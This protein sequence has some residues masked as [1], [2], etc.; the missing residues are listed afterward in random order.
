MLSSGLVSPTCSGCFLRQPKTHCLP[1][2][3][4]K[5]SQ[6]T[7]PFTINYDWKKYPQAKQRSNFSIDVSSFQVTL[8]SVKLTKPNHCSTLPPFSHLQGI[9]KHNTFILLIQKQVGLSCL[10][11]YTRG[12]SIL[13]GTEQVFKPS[14]EGIRE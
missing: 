9:Y 3:E 13:P 7:G 12:I 6:W 2:Q 8:F 10:K 14:S 11:C 1:V 4:Q 5:H